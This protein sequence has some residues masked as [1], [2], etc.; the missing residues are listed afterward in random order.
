MTPYLSKQACANFSHRGKQQ[1]CEG[2]QTMHRKLLRR[3]AFPLSDVSAFL[4]HG[5]ELKK[6][7]KLEETKCSSFHFF[8]YLGFD[9]HP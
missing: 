1:L 4:S 3:K 5:A 8:R 2:E 7:D 9:E 6:K